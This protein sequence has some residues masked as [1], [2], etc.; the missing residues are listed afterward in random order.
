[1]AEDLADLIANLKGVRSYADLAAA[2]G[3]TASSWQRWGVKKSYTKDRFIEPSSV[4]LIAATLEVS[5]RR[6]WL[7]VGATYGLNVAKPSETYLS[8]A[9]SGLS[10]DDLTTKQVDLIVG[11]VRELLAA[12]ADPMPAK[13]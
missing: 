9:L 5:E 3:G 1:M 11:V 8:R 10:L 7:A 6:V 4:R 12:Q 2:S 13:D